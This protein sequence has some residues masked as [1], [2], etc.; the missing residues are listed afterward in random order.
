MIPRAARSRNKLAH[1]AHPGGVE[2]R[3]RLIQQQ[4]ARLAEQRRG[5]A[6]ALAHP[7]GVAADLVLGAIAKLDD[8][9]RL[10]DPRPRRR[11]RRARR[12]L[13]VGAAAQVGIEAR[14]LDEARHAL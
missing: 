1:V 14:R 8:L 4:Q 7:V 9:E 12:K 11:R 2:A 6:Q 3:R 5:D 10:V 13:E